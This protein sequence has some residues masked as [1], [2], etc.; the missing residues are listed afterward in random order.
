MEGAQLS[1]CLV[2]TTKLVIRVELEQQ[3]YADSNIVH[4][5]GT[6]FQKGFQAFRRCLKGLL[7]YLNVSCCGIVQ[8]RNFWMVLEKVRISWWAIEIVD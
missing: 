2:I 3:T 8:S 4:E 1:C 7:L 5:P 6:D